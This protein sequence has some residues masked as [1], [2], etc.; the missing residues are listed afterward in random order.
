MDPALGSCRTYFTDAG[1]CR[2][3]GLENRECDPTVVLIHGFTCDS[4]DWDIIAGQVCERRP[5]LAVELP[6]HGLLRDAPGEYSI[7][8]CARDIATIIRELGLKKTVLVGHSMG[9]R[10]SLELCSTQA[11]LVQGLILVDGSCVPG[12]PGQIQKDISTSVESNG[13]RNWIEAAYTTMMLDSLSASV[14]RK[15]IARA[16]QISAP[17]IIDYMASMGAW[18]KARFEDAVMDTT[19]PITVLQST[20]LDDNEMRC[21]IQVQPKSRWRDGIGAHR[22]DAAFHEVHD[23]GHFLM[24]EQPQLVS[25]RVEKTAQAH[26]DTHPGKIKHLTNQH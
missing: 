15:L 21:S 24:L 23:A 8:R 7:E 10:I 20:S 17:A 13:K 14:R 25:D 2:I 5:C 12:D 4:S 1:P 6:G 9:A 26:H 22:P 19:A 3:W 11:E 16:Q 18:D